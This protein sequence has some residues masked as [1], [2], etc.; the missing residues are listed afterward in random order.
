MNI[1]DTITDILFNKSK[2]LKNNSDMLKKQVFESMS[3]GHISKN[4]EDLPNADTFEI[5]FEQPLSEEYLDEE[6]SVEEIELNSF[7]P[8]K[9]LNS[10]IFP[11]NMINSEV[12]VKLLD[13]ADDFVDF[14]KIGWI[15]PKDV[16][17][18]GSIVGYNWSEYSDIDLHIVIDFNE[19]DVDK[20]MLEEYF[21]SKKRLW[22]KN[23]E[24]LRIYSFPVEVHVE[25]FGEPSN[26]NGR[27]SLET[28][29]W[30]DFPEPNPPIQLEKYEIKQKSMVLMNKI[31]DFE[32]KINI[33]F[34][35]K[36]KIK[37]YLEEI[38]KLSNYIINMRRDSIN[39]YG[40]NS[41][42]NFVFKVLRRSGYIG[43]LNE[44][45]LKTYNIYN[46][47]V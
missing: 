36:N 39:K 38:E 7:K 10:I 11:N 46:S 5:G 40:E 34:N 20:E 14:L 23:H 43:K 3:Y 17:L 22:N 27:Y 2:I 42:G 30:I 4:G 47:I 16:V 25:N 35:K 29:A 24:D 28:N 45:K 1:T 44:L 26:S 18:V 21:S 41:V 9:E 6:V 15:K 8:K 32:E 12:R 19:V 13:I 33:D 37:I 31:D